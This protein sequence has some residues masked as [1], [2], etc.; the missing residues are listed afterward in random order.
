MQSSFKTCALDRSEFRLKLSIYNEV[1]SMFFHYAERCFTKIKKL[2]GILDFLVKTTP[3]SLTSDLDDM[4][5]ED[6]IEDLGDAADDED[7][8]ELLLD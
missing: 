6:E 7:D 1:K 4:H 3:P 5:L 8:I 2:E